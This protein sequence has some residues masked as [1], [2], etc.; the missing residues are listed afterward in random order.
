VRRRNFVLAAMLVTAAAC[1]DAASDTSGTTSVTTSGASTSSASSR[2]TTDSAEASPEPPTSGPTEA[3][4][5]TTP[6]SPPPSESSEP[7]NLSPPADTSNQPETSDQTD[8]TETSDQT[9]QTETSDQT[10]QTETSDQTDQE[11]VPL[12]PT[13]TPAAV[14]PLYEAGDIDRGLRPFIDQAKDDLAVRLGVAVDAISTHAAVL[15]VWPDASLGC[16]SPDMRYA[17]VLTDGSVIELGYDG[18]IYRYHTGGDRGPFICEQP[19]TKTPPSEGIG[20]G[21]GGEDI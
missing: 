1:D 19:L 11:S 5:P 9:D 15:V 13:P 3:S 12:V 10:D 7:S 17:Q 16:P 4:N 14:A 20:L 2:V 18:H 21:S 8:Q 6:E